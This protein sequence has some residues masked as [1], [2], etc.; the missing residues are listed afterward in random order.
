MWSPRRLAELAGTSRRAVRHYAE[1]GLLPEPDRAPNGY[2]RYGADQLIRLLRIRRLTDLGLTLP[3]IAAIG[4]ADSP[5]DEMIRGLDAELAEQ[6]TRIQRIRADLA[7]MLTRPGPFDLPAEI[8]QQLT[9]LPPAERKLVIILSRLLDPPA[10][11]TYMALLKRYRSGVDGVDAFDA[12]APDAGLG[13]RIAVAEQMAE[14][15]EAF[16]SESAED[17]AVI[18]DALRRG[19]PPRRQTVHDVIPELYNPAQVD[20]LARLLDARVRHATEHR[21]RVPRA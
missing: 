21:S 19:S 20:V 5:P 8:E 2:G 13:Q 9:D 14:P 11:S 1:I 3:Q 18:D 6:I 17:I 12:L 16:F 10:L 7:A 4:N 15:L